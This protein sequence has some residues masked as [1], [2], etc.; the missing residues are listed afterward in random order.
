MVVVV[1]RQRVVGMI[2]HCGHNDAA[3][4][5][6]PR[7]KSTFCPLVAEINE[8]FNAAATRIAD[9]GFCAW[10]QKRVATKKFSASQSPWQLG[11]I[12]FPM[13][14]SLASVWLPRGL[15]AAATV[16]AATMTACGV[17]SAQAQPPKCGDFMQLRTEAQQ[18]AAAVRDATQH[19]AERKKVCELVTRFST[20]EETVIKFLV[21][22][23][24]G[25]GVPDM[26][27]T[28]AKSAHENTLKF[29]KLA[30]TEAP[31]A[32]PRQPSLSDA[33]S[34]PSV[35][36]GANT[37]TGRGTLDSLSGNPLAR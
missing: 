35:D 31:A 14:R 36:T 15:I 24:M 9:S 13:K 29:Q 7:R 27:I 23:K 32:Q 34:Q 18:R 21:A 30:C 5:S 25:C 12:I 2:E 8:P 28:Q 4:A 37:H 33:I 1:W 11:R 10:H 16:A 22:N 17:A 3:A 6:H 20:A 19:K 26:A